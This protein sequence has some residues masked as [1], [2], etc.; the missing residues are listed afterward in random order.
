M[1]ES[2]STVAVVQ[3]TTYAPKAV[4]RAVFEALSLLGGP[5]RFIR[6]GWRVLIK[7]NL[8]VPVG[9]DIPA[10]THP[11]VICAVAEWVREAGAI[12]LV[13]D[14]PAWGDV[15]AC[16]AALGIVERLNASGVEIVRLDRPVRI[17]I[18]GTSIGLSRTA[19]QADAIINLPKLKA[20]QQLGA[21][22]AVKNMY[23]CVV[24]KEKAFWH[25]A[26]G[27]S[28]DGFCRMLIG[29]YRRLAPVVNLIDGIIAMEGQ[30]PINGCPRSLGVLVA[31][32]DAVACEYLCCRLIG[33]DP[34]VLPILQTAAKMNFG[35]QNDEAIQT[36]GDLWQPLIC[37][38]FAPAVLSPLRFTFWRICK[39]IAKQAGLLYPNLFGRRPRTR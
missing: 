17:L 11:E 30:G 18:E 15:Q 23:G 5:E 14:S 37:S 24:G 22:F 8:I 2:K 26:K 33:F 27:H 1:T 36:L 9:P 25:F 16:L 6:P 29:V 39:S 13:G 31:G 10:Q 21:T 38:D 35:C 20:H 4:R 12:P 19:L 32:T 28:F 34:A 7:P 3:C